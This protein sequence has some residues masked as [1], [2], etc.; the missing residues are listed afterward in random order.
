[1]NPGEKVKHALADLVVNLV[2]VISSKQMVGLALSLAAQYLAAKN[3][4][5]LE[6]PIAIAGSAHATWRG[7]ADTWGKGK[8]QV[9]AA[10]ALNAA[11]SQ[12]FGGKLN[13]KG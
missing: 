6:V 2:G 1:M 11:S 10:A 7:C 5:N 9:Q 3:G 13:T 4:L 12:R 8:V